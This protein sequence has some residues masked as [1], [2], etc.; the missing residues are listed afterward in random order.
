MLKNKTLTRSKTNRTLTGVL[1][2]IG[3]YFE[4]DP[5][6]LRVVFVILTAFSGFVPGVVAYALMAVIMPEASVSAPKTTK[7]TKKTSAKTAKK[8]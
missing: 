4:V 1:G 5:V 2:G 8:K 7:T 6:L 3:E